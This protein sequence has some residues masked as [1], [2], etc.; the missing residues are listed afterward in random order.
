MV[1]DRA[2]IG[3]E[4]LRSGRVAYCAGARRN[5]Q[6]QYPL[7]FYNLLIFEAGLQDLRQAR[8]CFASWDIPGEC[9]RQLSADYL[10]GFLQSLLSA[11]DQFRAANEQYWT[12]GR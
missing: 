3:L 11:A 4:I 5:R 2:D 1:D 9:L 10:S 8:R 6:L 12:S 7:E